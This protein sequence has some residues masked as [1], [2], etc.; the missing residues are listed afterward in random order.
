LKTPY[1]DG[2]LRDG[3]ADA[4]AQPVA[5]IVRARATVATVAFRI[6]IVRLP[7]LLVRHTAGGAEHE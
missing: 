7:S 2:G 3:L 6:R 5:V 1:V 4:L